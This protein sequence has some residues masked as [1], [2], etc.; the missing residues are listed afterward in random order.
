MLTEVL[1]QPSENGRKSRVTWTDEMEQKAGRLF[2]AGMPKDVVAQNVGVS[3]ATL[4]RKAPQ[5]FKKR[6]EFVTSVPKDAATSP[7]ATVVR[8]T[9][10]S[11]AEQYRAELK[12]QAKTLENEIVAMRAKI[13]EL[14]ELEKRIEAVK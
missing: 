14:E 6:G 8:F 9:K 13:D 1:E 4:R 12:V 11:L 10:G 3:I 5:F 2:K 7:S